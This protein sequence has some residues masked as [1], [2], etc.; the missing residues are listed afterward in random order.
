[1]NAAAAA[2]VLAPALA[3]GSFLLAGCTRTLGEGDPDVEAARTFD[4]YPLYWVGEHF[5]EWDLEHINVAPGGFST[6]IYGTC[7]L[8]PEGA[9]GPQRQRRHFGLIPSLAPAPHRTP[10]RVLSSRLASPALVVAI[11]PK[12]GKQLAS[13]L[14]CRVPV[15]GSEEAAEFVPEVLALFR[16]PA[17]S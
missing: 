14:R 15:S 3:L 12:G 8:G 17:V 5:E 10:L 13:R 16:S 4:R 9:A 1:V 2:F 6:F 7:E 11:E